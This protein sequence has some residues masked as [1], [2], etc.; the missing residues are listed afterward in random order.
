MARARRWRRLPAWRRRRQLGES[1]ALAAAAARWRRGQRQRGCGSAVVAAGQLG[2]SGGGSLARARCW[3]R[4]QHG[5]G[6][7]SGS[8]AVAARRRRSASLAAEAVAWRKRDFGRS[9]SSKCF[10]T[11]ERGDSSGRGYY[12]VPMGKSVF[13]FSTI[14]SR[15]GLRQVYDGRSS[16]QIISIGNDYWFQC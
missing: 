16:I 10:F 7:A 11:P 15:E 5:G 14:T 13:S 9:S 12:F 4:R 1:A 6:V 2:G 3:R 8:A